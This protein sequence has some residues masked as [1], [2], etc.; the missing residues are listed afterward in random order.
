MSHYHWNI[1]STYADQIEDSKE[2]PFFSGISTIA[3]NW[4]VLLP[5]KIYENIGT[6]VDIRNV[7]CFVDTDNI[8]PYPYR[9]TC[10]H[11]KYTSLLGHLVDEDS[12]KWFWWS[13]DMKSRLHLPIDRLKRIRIIKNVSLCVFDNF[14]LSLTALEQEKLFCDKLC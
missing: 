14:S 6:S 5:P 13:I 1:L 10:I 2:P 12:D 7:L 8:L 3:A 11:P 9:I 4:S